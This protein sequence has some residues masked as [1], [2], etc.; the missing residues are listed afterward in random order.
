[1]EIECLTALVGDCWPKAPL[2][3][4]YRQDRRLLGKSSGPKVGFPEKSCSSAI[5]RE[6]WPVGSSAALQL[7]L[8]LPDRQGPG[9]GAGF[10][11]LR[12][13]SAAGLLFWRSL[14]ALA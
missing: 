6:R 3:S 7:K 13:A 12:R 1:M 5:N 2:S 9:S 4:V 10:V 11:F 8:Q 14:F